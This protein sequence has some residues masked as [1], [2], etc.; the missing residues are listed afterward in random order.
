MA[1]DVCDTIESRENIVFEN[2]NVFAFLNQ[3]PACMGHVTIVPKKHFPIIENVP[4]F[5]VAD[6]F[7]VANKISSAIF[8][9]LGAQGT[10]IIVNNGVDAGQKKPHASV[11]V[12]ARKE[13][14][15]LNFQWKPKQ[16]TQEEMSTVEL[17]IREKTKNIGEFQKE[18]AKPISMDK[19]TEKI[20]DEESMLVDQLNRLP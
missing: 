3:T 10:N 12:L 14:D 8:E 5:I 19:K 9:S 20:S 4:D 2:N 18:E 13:K 11:E 7:K 1:C 15:N 17:T 16:L 6:M